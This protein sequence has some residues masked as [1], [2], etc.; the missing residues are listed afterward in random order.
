QNGVDNA[1]LL[2]SR[3][4]EAVVLGG[5]SR[6]EAYVESPGVVVQR[7]QQQE[8]TLGAFRS[9][10][11]PAAESLAA[12]LGNAGVPVT[13]TDDVVAALWLK[14]LITSGPG[15]MSAFARHPIGEALAAPVERS[16]L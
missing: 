10:D 16:L 1:D 14:L 15:S 2:R 7:G 9:E 13:V 6:I 12:A 11:R 5:T 4:P 3:F 8:V